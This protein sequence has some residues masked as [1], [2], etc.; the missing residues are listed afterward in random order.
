MGE[1]YNVTMDDV[2]AWLESKRCTPEQ[3]A[4]G[5]GWW[6]RSAIEDLRNG[7]PAKALDI[8]FGATSSYTH[9]YW[10]HNKERIQREQ[11][12]LKFLEKEFDREGMDH[13][14]ESTWDN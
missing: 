9:E 7:N 8:L 3:E 10:E 5:L 6:V 11:A 14:Y 4:K 2:F 13:D 12:L 1:Q